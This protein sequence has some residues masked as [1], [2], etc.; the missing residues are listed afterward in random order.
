MLVIDAT[1][2]SIRVSSRATPSEVSV[3]K[4]TIGCVVTDSGHAPLVAIE[5]D[6]DNRDRV[7]DAELD[8][9]RELLTSLRATMHRIACGQATDDD[10]ELAARASEGV[11][12]E[13]ER[14]RLALF[15]QASGVI[16]VRSDS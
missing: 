12:H 14:L 5:R 4:A 7:S 16:R 2:I 10:L 8:R 9:L 11:E 3:E 6:I 13:V 15:T 1:T